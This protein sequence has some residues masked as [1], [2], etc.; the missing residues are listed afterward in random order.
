MNLDE[1]WKKLT[2]EEIEKVELMMEDEIYVIVLQ[3]IEHYVT[4]CETFL[5][6]PMADL[7]VADYGEVVSQEYN[8]H[9]CNGKVVAYDMDTAYLHIINNHLNEDDEDD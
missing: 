2:K 4:N 8:C 1:I 9:L 6:K 5:D 7:E 3:Y